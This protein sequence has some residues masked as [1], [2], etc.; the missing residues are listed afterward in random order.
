LNR[1]D[2]DIVGSILLQV[3]L[4]AV[5]AV[6]ACAEIAV[7]SCN[8]AKLEKMAQEGNKKAAKL[9]RLTEQPSRFLATIQVVITLSGFLGSAFAAE[10]FSGRFVSVLV[11]AGV[12]IPEKTLDAIAVVLITL[13]LSYITLIFGE[14]VPKRLAMHNSEKIALGVSGLVTTASKIFAPLVGLL[15]VSTNGILRLFGI[16]PNE[17]DDQVTEEE[18]RM[19]VDAGS[20]KGTIDNEEKDMIQN[21]FEFDE[22]ARSTKSAST[23]PMW[24]FCGWRIRLRSG[25]SS[26]MRAATRITRSAA[27]LWTISSAFWMPRI[28]SGFAPR[29]A[30]MS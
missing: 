29:T 5:N 13:L 20:E 21:V 23:G 28:I 11:D 19:M 27:K 24:I 22:S 2:S 9:F 7:V 25:S 17:D 18:I 3:V 10:N 6:F 1:L 4:I 30:I 26:S 15:T 8:D 12:Q 14:L 16:D